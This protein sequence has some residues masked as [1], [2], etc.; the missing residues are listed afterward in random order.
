MRDHQAKCMIKK[1]HQHSKLVV[2]WSR[3]GYWSL[4]GRSYTFYGMT[5]GVLLKWL[6]FIVLY[7]IEEL[8]LVT[9]IIF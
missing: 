1:S 7:S 5:E 8:A 4:R 6:L 2:R 3:S 9:E